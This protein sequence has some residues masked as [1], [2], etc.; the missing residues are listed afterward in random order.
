M[1]GLTTKKEALLLEFIKA[2][3]RGETGATI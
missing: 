3:K 2:E 1:C